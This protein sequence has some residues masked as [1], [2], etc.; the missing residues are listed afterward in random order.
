VSHFRVLGQ[1]IIEAAIQKIYLTPE[2]PPLSAVIEE[3]A[4]QCF[5]AKLKTPDASTVRT[6]P[7]SFVAA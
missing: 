4:L 5:K 6:M 2:Q 3:V 1:L 7:K